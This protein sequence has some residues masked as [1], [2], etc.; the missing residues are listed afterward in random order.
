MTPCMWGIPGLIVAA[1]LSGLPSGDTRAQQAGAQVESGGNV[2]PGEVMLGTVRLPTAVLADGERL[3][4]GTYR[5]RLT[6]DTAEP[7]VAGQRASLERWVEIMQG[8]TVRA[9]TM[10]TIIPGSEIGEVAQGS[11]PAPGER[12]VE[13]LKGDEYVRIWVNVRGDHVLLHLPITQ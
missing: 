4:P 5:L 2:L 3:E 1:A 8:S 11:P 9:R 12:R 6:P 7:E 13:R 10:A